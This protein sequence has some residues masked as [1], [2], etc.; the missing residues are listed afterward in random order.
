QNRE[1]IG[2]SEFLA[3]CGLGRSGARLSAIRS[4]LAPR[5]DRSLRLN[6]LPTRGG[7]C[8]SRVARQEHGASVSSS[9]WLQVGPVQIVKPSGMDLFPADT[10][11]LEAGL[12][13]LTANERPRSMSSHDIDSQPVETT[14]LERTDR[15]NIEDL[16]SGHRTHIFESHHSCESNISSSV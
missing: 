8:R 4:T 1:Q 11:A 2:C 7:G 15:R 14:T 3:G 13:E 12:L 9:K 10:R 16:R 6:P 5:A